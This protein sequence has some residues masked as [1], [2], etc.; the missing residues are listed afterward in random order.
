MPANA[1][2]ENFHKK[3]FLFLLSMRGN[4]LVFCGAP[5]RDD[6]GKLQH[7]GECRK[8]GADTREIF[9]F[10]MYV[11]WDED[12]HS[13]LTRKLVNIEAFSGCDSTSFPTSS[14]CLILQWST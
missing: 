8:R 11:D 2:R 4:V 6:G 12:L 1:I 5:Q 10:T 13:Q 14:K 7:D 9:T 3:V